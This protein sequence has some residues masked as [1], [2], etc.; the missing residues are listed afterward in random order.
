MNRT[1]KRGEFTFVD[2]TGEVKSRME[3]LDE[4]KYDAAFQKI[5]RKL[6]KIERRKRLMNMK[7]AR[8]EGGEKEGNMSVQYFSTADQSPTRK[9]A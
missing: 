6:S 2:K 7:P 4:Q 3:E 8:T 9:P 5:M 1:A